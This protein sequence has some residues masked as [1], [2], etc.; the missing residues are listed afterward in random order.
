MDF[1]Y[2][3]MVFSG[4]SIEISSVIVNEASDKIEI[5]SKILCGD[6]VVIDNAV[7]FIGFLNE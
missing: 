3:S 4:E 6:R 2:K 1:Q 5:Q 7:S